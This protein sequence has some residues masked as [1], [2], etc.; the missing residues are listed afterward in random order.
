MSK[1]PWT[2]SKV[3]KRVVFSVALVRLLE[4]VLLAVGDI[5][6]RLDTKEDAGLRR[7]TEKDVEN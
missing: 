5:Q 6:V 1:K 2:C 3:S 4:V 7:F